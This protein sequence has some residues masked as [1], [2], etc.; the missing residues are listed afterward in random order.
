MEGVEMQIKAI[1]A[2]CGIGL[3]WSLMS[4]GQVT[5]TKYHYVMVQQVKTPDGKIAEKTRTQTTYRARDGRER[6]DIGATTVQIFQPKTKSLF[7]L[8]VDKKTYYRVPPAGSRPIKGAESFLVAGNQ[9]TKEILGLRCEKSATPT[10]GKGTYFETWTCRD[11]ESSEHNSQISAETLVRREDGT[12]YHLTLQQITPNVKVPAF[13]FEI[14]GNFQLT[15]TP[16]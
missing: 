13:F 11:P 2:F 15:E 10:N 14:P 1:L 9:G 7:I 5:A 8:N 4:V 12:G 6:G 16:D 3:G